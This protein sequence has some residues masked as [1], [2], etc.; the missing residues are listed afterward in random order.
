MP[1]RRQGNF[2]PMKK[3]PSRD[4]VEKKLVDLAEGRITREAADKWASQWV[5]GDD[6]M[7]PVMDK[8]VWEALGCLFGAESKTG[9]NTYLHGAEDFQA[10]L[11]NFRE[12]IREG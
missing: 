11:E 4:E 3:L 6:E 7:E 9:P 12:G 5:L 1:N 8:L 2:E 10:W